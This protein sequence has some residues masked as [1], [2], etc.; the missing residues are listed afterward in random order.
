VVITYI[1]YD[2]RDEYVRIK[3]RGTTG[4]SMSGWWL[5]DEADNTY[6]FPNIALDAGAHV[7]IHSGPDAYDDPPADYLWTR[8]YIWNNGGDTAYLYDAAGRLVDT[9]SY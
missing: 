7:R 1:H 5:K 4:Q 6:Y 8:R 2:A 9:Y 3:N